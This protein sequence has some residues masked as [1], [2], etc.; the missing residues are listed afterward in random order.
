M[1]SDMDVDLEE[2]ISILESEQLP[3]IG[4]DSNASD[5]QTI[6]GLPPTPFLEELLEV[7]KQGNYSQTLSD[8]NA[9]LPSIGLDSDASDPQTISGLP[10]T[11]FSEEL[12]EVEKQG[13]YSQTLSDMDADLEELISILGLEQ[14]PS[15]GLDSDALDP[16]TLPWLSLTPFFEEFSNI[17][18]DTDRRT[19]SYGGVGAATKF[20][21]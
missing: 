4:L 21:S 12:L 9:D 14:L 2:L 3:S 10:P 8:I 1:L 15:I 20:Q 19:S 17:D 18:A 6:S 13:N 7:E 16:H 5:P 11:L